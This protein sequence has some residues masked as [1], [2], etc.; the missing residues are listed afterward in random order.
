[1]P[2]HNSNVMKL[3]GNAA[4]PR[5]L[6]F[7]SQVGIFH[8]L[9]SPLHDDVASKDESGEKEQHARGLSSPIWL[10]LLLKRYTVGT[11]SKCSA[12]KYQ[13][14]FKVSRSAADFFN[15]S[16]QL[17]CSLIFLAFPNRS[18]ALR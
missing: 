12:Y 6:A 15:S 10:E 17:T 8:T 14:T 13:D 2:Y 11:F 1:M 16:S 9:Q 4:V 7:R 3:E 18:L 5:K